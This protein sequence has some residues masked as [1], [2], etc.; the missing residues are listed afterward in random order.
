MNKYIRKTL[1]W[2][3]L[4]ATLFFFWRMNK[5]QRKNAKDKLENWRCEWRKNSVAFKIARWFL[6]NVL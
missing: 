3:Q 2:V 5:S 6:N 4:P 1:D